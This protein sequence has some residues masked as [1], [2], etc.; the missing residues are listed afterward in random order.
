MPGRAVRTRREEFSA[1]FTVENI[2]VARGRSGRPLVVV[3]SRNWSFYPAQVAVL[4][5]TGALLREYWHSG[6]FLLLETADLDRDGSDE[7]YLGGTNNGRRQAE[8]V[9]LDPETLDGAGDESANPD[10]Q[11]LGFRPGREIRRVLFPPSCL[12]QVLAIRSGIRDLVIQGSEITVSVE[13]GNM[14][15]PYA[16]A[17]YTLSPAG[18]LISVSLSD[19][20]PQ[21]HAAV[22]ADGRVKHA[23]DRAKE[24]ADLSK[25]EVIEASSVR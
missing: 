11:L 25:L 22:E 23:F 18:K 13:Q 7:I 15:G 17:F 8:L 4:D 3:Q 24:E 14:G 6:G 5:A 10:Y 9:I 21:I 2:G 20:Y 16:S 19:G 12:S 1:Y